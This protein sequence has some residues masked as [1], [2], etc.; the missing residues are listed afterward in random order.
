MP[1]HSKWNNRS[2]FWMLFRGWILETT[3]VHKAPSG[4]WW[5]IP[6]WLPNS[7][8]LTSMTIHSL[9]PWLPIH[10]FLTSMVTHSALPWLPIPP[11]LTSMITNSSLSSHSYIHGDAS[12]LLPFLH[13]WLS[14]PH[15]L[16]SIPHFI[17]TI[18]HL[19]LPCC[20][21]RLSTPHFLTSIPHFITTIPHLSL[22]WLPIPPSLPPCCSKR[23]PTLD[24][25]GSRPRLAWAYFCTNQMGHKK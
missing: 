11:F 16:T 25:D 17:T 9:L 13:P 5:Q 10:L 23:S 4:I 7:P 18:P 6:L 19:S 1:E 3:I 8:F 12:P 14:T 24:G 15:F 22:P 21:K 2:S 20:S